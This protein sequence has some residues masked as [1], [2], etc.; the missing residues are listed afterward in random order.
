VTGAGRRAAASEEIELALE[1]LRVA[2]TLLDAGF[3]RVALTRAYFAVFHAVRAR[4]YAEGIEPRS[5]GSTSSSSICT[6]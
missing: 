5:H 2:E 3:Y 4:L 6:W 1:E